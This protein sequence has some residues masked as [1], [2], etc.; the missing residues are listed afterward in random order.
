VRRLSLSL[1]S[2]RDVRRLSLSLL[3][4]CDRLLTCLVPVSKSRPNK[5]WYTQIRTC[6]CMKS[7]E[8]HE[9]WVEMLCMKSLFS[10]GK[11]TDMLCMKSH[12]IAELTFC[13][14]F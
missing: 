4:L 3:S 12:E 2:N 5:K 1:L 10:T 13:N 8:M 6:V 14:F 11:R 7:L 9:P